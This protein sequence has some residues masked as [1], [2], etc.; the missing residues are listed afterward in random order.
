MQ[1]MHTQTGAAA[2]RGALQGTKCAWLAPLHLQHMN[3]LQEC[4]QGAAR[5]LSAAQSSGQKSLELKPWDQ[6]M[7]FALSSGHAVNNILQPCQ[8]AILDHCSALH[9]C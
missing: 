4:A 2:A 5:V 1:G 8:Q 7:E 6:H 3:K 9:A